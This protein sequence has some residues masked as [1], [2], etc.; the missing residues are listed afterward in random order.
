MFSWHPMSK[1]QVISP[2][3]TKICLDC[4]KSVWMKLGMGSWVSR[5]REKAT[6][7]KENIKS[8]PTVCSR[9]MGFFLVFL[10]VGWSLGLVLAPRCGEGTISI[11][12]RGYRVKSILY[13]D[14]LSYVHADH[15]RGMIFI[16]ILDIWKWKK[17]LSRNPN[18]R[19]GEMT[20]FL[21]LDSDWPKG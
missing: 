4:L 11:H 21:P 8:E 14:V 19:P 7:S 15:S 17:R 18:L 1:N 5:E 2:I 16:G 3:Q 13:H 12:L 9:E 20:V 6:Q 10:P